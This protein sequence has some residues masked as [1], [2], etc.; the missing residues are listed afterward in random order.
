MECQRSIGGEY[1]EKIIREG[2]TIYSNDYCR[3]NFE[4]DQDGYAYV[5]YY[6]STGKLQQLYPDSAI[7]IP[8]KVKGNTR[9]TIPAEGNNWFQLDNHR[10]TETVFVLAS[11]EPIRDFN[12]TFST[13][14]GLSKEE[15]VKTFRGKATVLKVL[16]FKHQ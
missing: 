7:A 14:Q 12:E 10:G 3:I 11:R 9:Y 15:V 8:Q 16:R 5:L 1:E 4:L 13:I 6:D 2:D